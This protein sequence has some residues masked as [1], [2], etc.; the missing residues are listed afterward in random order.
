MN[1]TTRVIPTSI[2]VMWTRTLRNNCS[3]TKTGLGISIISRRRACGNRK[4]KCGGDWENVSTLS[5]AFLFLESS[6]CPRPRRETHLPFCHDYVIRR[7]LPGRACHNHLFLTPAQYL[8]VEYNVEISMIDVDMA[9]AYIHR[10]LIP[11]KELSRPPRRPSPKPTQK[12]E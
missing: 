10:A 4:R 5:A 8:G 6:L 11:S 1:S 12:P 7:A 3:R 9:V 2:S